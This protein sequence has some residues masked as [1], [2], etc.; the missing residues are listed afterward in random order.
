MLQYIELS[1]DSHLIVVPKKPNIPEPI[2][3]P[4]EPELDLN[5][6][7]FAILYKYNII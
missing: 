5:M 6:E 3:P 2:I 4:L 1:V 7:L